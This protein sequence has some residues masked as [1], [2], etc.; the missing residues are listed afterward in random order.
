MAEFTIRD[1][2]VDQLLT[3]MSIGYSNPL[4]IADN[5][6]PQVPVNRQT[7]FIPQYVQ[8]DWFRNNAQGRAVGTR[9][10]RGSFNLDNTM[11]YACLR[12]SFGV[13]IPDEVRDNTDAPYDMDRDGALFA[14][15]RIAMYREVSAAAT[16]FTTSVWTGD[17]T[18]VASGPGANQFIQW[19]NYDTSSPLVDLTIWSDLIEGRVGREATQITLGKLVWSQLKWHPDILDLI[20]Y[21]QTAIVTPDLVTR[22]ADIGRLHIGRGIYTTDPEGTA[23]ASVTYSRIWGKHVLL[24]YMPERASLMTPAAAYALTWTRVPS[25]LQYV[26]RMRDEEREVDI[27]EGNTYFQHKVTVPRAGVFANGAI[28]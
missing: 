16:L 11:T 27:I 13:E 14:A 7:G 5:L 18:G 20:R 1:P 9:S 12:A 25:S 21:T 23:E 17:Q 2:H 6:A 19:N 28:A 8:S 10:Q 22:L 26:K 15:D 3:T 4:Y 24:Q